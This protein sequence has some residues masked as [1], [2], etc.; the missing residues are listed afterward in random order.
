MSCVCTN[1]IMHSNITHMYM[2]RFY[3]ELSPEYK[4]FR[5]ER[6]KFKNIMFYTGY[7]WVCNVGIICNE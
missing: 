6:D 2:F 3:E 5:Y 7:M 4:T 1:A